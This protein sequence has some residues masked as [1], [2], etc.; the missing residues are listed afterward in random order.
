MT[1]LNTKLPTLA[2]NSKW[3]SALDQC[4]PDIVAKHISSFPVVNVISFAELSD[5]LVSAIK[6]ERYEHLSV[7]LTGAR[8]YVEPA[9]RSNEWYYVICGIHAVY[10]DFAVFWSARGPG[11]GVRP[12]PCFLFCDEN[13]ISEKIEEAA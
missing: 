2:K 11:Y 13:S 12:N 5:I 1:D 3:M 10:G 9:Q 7:K 6:Y 8:F 4:S